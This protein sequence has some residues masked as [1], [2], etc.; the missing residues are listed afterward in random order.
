VKK[1][2]T[3]F[4]REQKAISTIISAVLMVSIASIAIAV[5]YSWHV[6]LIQ[7]LTGWAQAESP[8]HLKRIVI[9]DVSPQIAGITSLTIKIQNKGGENETLDTIYV[10]DET[11]GEQVAVFTN[12][13]TN[14][15]MNQPPVSVQVQ[16]T[17][18][19]VR[20][21]QYHIKTAC[22]SGAT[23]EYVFITR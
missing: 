17:T 13:Y 5:V 11:A 19:L 21:H 4:L 6:G 23:A 20:G 9:T 18:S 8:G 2:L 3:H 12:L 22:E 16:L 14:V 7:Q 10:S 15:P 1:L